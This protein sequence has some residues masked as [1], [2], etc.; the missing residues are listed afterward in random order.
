MIDLIIL[1]VT[2]FGGLGAM[3]SYLNNSARLQLRDINTTEKRIAYRRQIYRKRINAI[4]AVASVPIIILVFCWITM[5]SITATTEE[6]W[7]IKNWL[8]MSYF[9]LLTIIII[10]GP[11]VLY[12][13]F[14]YKGNISYFNK[15]AFLEEN[16]VFALYLRGFENDDYS[17]KWGLVK[18]GRKQFSE[19]LFTKILSKYCVCSAIGMTKEL[20]APLGAKRIYVDDET[21]KDVVAELMEKSDK[22]YILINNRPSC[23]WEIE[24][25]VQYIEKVVMIIDD[26]IKYVLVQE[27][28]KDTIDLPHIQDLTMNNRYYFLQYKDGV[29][30]DYKYHNS[31]DGYNEIVR[32][33]YS[34]ILSVR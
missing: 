21:W 10:A 9:L 30:E 22:I 13:Y 18:K 23:I 1:L 2:A 15:K 20:D 25:A 31:R 3:I 6:I 12:M 11:L 33:T 32:I 26:P 8:E 17:N 16:K 7:D 27:A 19:Y 28:V 29:F 34:D 4:F 24:S 5:M 14:Q